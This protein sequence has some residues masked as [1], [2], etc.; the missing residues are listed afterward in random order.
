MAG[1]VGSNLES[2]LSRKSD[3]E[4]ADLELDLV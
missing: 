4:L 1:I 2:Y 3:L